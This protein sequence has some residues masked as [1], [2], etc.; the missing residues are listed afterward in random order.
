MAACGGGRGGMDC[1]GGNKESF[2][3][4]GNVLYHHCSISEVCVP[5]TTHPVVQVK[6]MQFII[7]KLYINKIDLK[8]K[9]KKNDYS[10]KSLN[11]WISMRQ[12]VVSGIPTKYKSRFWRV[13]DSCFLFFVSFF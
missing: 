4:Y 13:S 12:H 5:V 10:G 8:T 6:W 1:N 11:R 7:P 3:D 9:K 2:E